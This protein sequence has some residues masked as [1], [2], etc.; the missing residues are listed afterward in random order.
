MHKI[1]R[2]IKY[3]GQATYNVGRRFGNEYREFCFCS[4]LMPSLCFSVIQYVWKLYSCTKQ[5][6]NLV[7]LTLSTQID[8][9]WLNSNSMVK[10]TVEL[11]TVESLP[12]QNF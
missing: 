7:V 8:S 9:H 10:G 11:L 4:F 6:Q 12:H 5:V 2:L 1:L 3:C